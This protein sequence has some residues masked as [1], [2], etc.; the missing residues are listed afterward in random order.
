V[1]DYDLNM[2]LFSALL[3]CLCRR[4][5]GKAFHTRGPAAEKLVSPKLCHCCVYVGRHIILSDA[6]WS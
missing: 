3:K 2:S 5:D 6:D 4:Y 1:V